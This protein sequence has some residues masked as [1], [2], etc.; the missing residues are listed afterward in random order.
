MEVLMKRVLPFLLVLFLPVAVFAQAPQSA[1]TKLLKQLGLNDGQ[2]SQVL[3]IQG[4][5]MTTARA[6]AVQ[7]RLL[8]AQLDKALLPAGPD[9]QAVNG[10]I[11]QI[12]QTR[13][14]MQKTLVAARV[15]LRQI[16]GD[17]NFR[18]YMRHVRQSLAFNA[19]RAMRGH[20][21]GGGMREG[22]P[23]YGGMMDGRG[24]DG[25]SDLTLGS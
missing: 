9:M 22:G 1:Q 14:D 11:A 6:D 23:L 16:M 7:L 21:F 8:R 13:V 2:V 17:G 24:P 12:G 10:I 19:R 18:V 15:Q 25:G 20:G 5:S 4:K 3:D